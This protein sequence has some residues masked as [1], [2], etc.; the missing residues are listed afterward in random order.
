MENISLIKNLES[1]LTNLLMNNITSIFNFEQRKNFGEAIILYCVSVGG[2][3]S[4]VYLI[5]IVLEQIFGIDYVFGFWFGKISAI[6]AS[7][8]LSLRILN[9]RKF[10]FINKVLLFVGIIFTGAYGFF[11]GMIPLVI[12]ALSYD[13]NDIDSNTKLD[14]TFEEKPL[15]VNEKPVE[16]KPPIVKQ[17][18]VEVD[19]ISSTKN[20]N[21]SELAT[22]LTQLNELK[23]KGILTEEEFSEQKKKLLKI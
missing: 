13:K 4:I 18:P 8:F 3:L 19:T 23:E 22:N 14:P 12:V 2:L 11:I 20:N 1:E 21:I 15:V 10:G 9:Q 5:A 7:I 16:E 6:S 17:K